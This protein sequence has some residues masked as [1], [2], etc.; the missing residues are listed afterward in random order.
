MALKLITERIPTFAPPVDNVYGTLTEITRK[1]ILSKTANRI[2]AFVQ[3]HAKTVGLLLCEPSAVLSDQPNYYPPS[4]WKALGEEGAV[5]ADR[6]SGGL[7]VVNLKNPL[8][9]DGESMPIGITL[10]HEL[11]H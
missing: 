9:L 1:T 4:Q 3:V 6:F 8:N 7:A 10:A 5:L 2:I 11:G